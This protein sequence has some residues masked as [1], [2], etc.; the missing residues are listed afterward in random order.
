MLL[1]S[2]GLRPRQEEAKDTSLLL[3]VLRGLNR[4]STR[5][6]QAHK[7][8]PSCKAS[9][10]ACASLPQAR[11]KGTGT[12]R[13]FLQAAPTDPANANAVESCKALARQVND[14]K[15]LVPQK[16]EGNM[17]GSCMRNTSK[18]CSSTASIGTGPTSS[19][20]S[21]RS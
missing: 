12:W 18:K 15:H 10:A 3:V 20:S 6:Q 2:E 14:D 11:V 8:L 16:L 1:F 21:T 17:H 13:Y 7:T 9:S 19:R 4:L 5:S